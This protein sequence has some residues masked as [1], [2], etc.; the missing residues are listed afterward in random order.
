MGY[1]RLAIIRVSS[2]QPT[3]KL[4]GLHSAGLCLVAGTQRTTTAPESRKL[5]QERVATTTTGGDPTP[6]QCRLGNYEPAVSAEACD[7]RGR[8]KVDMC[9]SRLGDERSN[10]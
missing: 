3:H 10:Q 4:P 9:P 1:I 2:G 8:R 5:S 6:G 7:K